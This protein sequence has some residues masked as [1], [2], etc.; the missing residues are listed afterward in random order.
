M[1]K[2]KTRKPSKRDNSEISALPSGLLS[3]ASLGSEIAKIVQKNYV[4]YKEPNLFKDANQDSLKKLA[5]AFSKGWSKEEAAKVI[6]ACSNDIFNTDQYIDVSFLCRW[7]LSHPNDSRAVLDCMHIKAPDEINIIRVLSRAGSQK[8]VFLATWHL[9]QRQVVLKSLT[10]PPEVVD[11]ILMREKQPH[12]LSMKHPNI[13]ETHLLKNSFGETFLVEE[14]LPHLLDDEWRSCGIQEAAN[15]LYDISN[16]LNYLHKTLDLVHGDVKPDNI[17]KRGEDYILLDF[18]ICRSAE[19]F[20]ADATATGSIRTMAPELLSTDSYPHPHK[21]DVWAL[22][23]TVYN[24]LV[25]RFPLFDF[26]E[27]PPR[28]SSPEERTDFEKILLY[29]VENE[30]EKRVD[31]NLVDNSIRRLLGMMLEKDPVKRCTTEALMEDA[32]CSLA[33]F[34]RKPTQVGRFSPLD[35]LKQLEAFLPDS[36]ILNLMPITER[37]ALRSGLSE[38]RNIQGIDETQKKQVDRLIDKVG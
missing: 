14:R 24:S 34:L 25:G 12:P 2:P 28:V 16:A 6:T 9:T 38:L 23:A 26:D 22:G 32:E 4:A 8:L 3:I 29:R 11:H 33:A 19:S 20:S 1:A 31:L 18:G 10:G 17:G 15:L 36:D 37:D 35:E 30:W 7:V 27:T 5:D 21:V 13:I